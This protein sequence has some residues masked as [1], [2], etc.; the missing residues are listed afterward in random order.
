LQVNRHDQPL[1]NGWIGRLTG[2]DLFFSFSASLNCAD[3][4]SQYPL[5]FI[6]REALLSQRF[7]QRGRCLAQ[8]RPYLLQGKPKKLEHDDLLQGSKSRSVYIRYP[9]AV[10][11]GF[12]TPSR[13]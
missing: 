13:S 6:E 5:L 10:R 9:A 12:N 7:V 1:Q 8:H 11:R 3:C 2:S 4:S